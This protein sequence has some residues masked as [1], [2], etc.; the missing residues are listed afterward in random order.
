MWRRQEGSLQKP[1]LSGPDT[2]MHQKPCLDPLWASI[3]E[4]FGQ[5]KSIPKR[6]GGH[7][8]GHWI[9]DLDFKGWA[10]S[11]GRLVSTPGSR[12]PLLG[13]ICTRTSRALRARSI[14]LELDFELCTTFGG[15]VRCTRQRATFPLSSKNRDHFPDPPWGSV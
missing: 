4:P 9:L 8:D 15:E 2:A 3:W 10:R 13:Y 11:W 5:P 1:S 12:D 6:S 7:Q 14:L